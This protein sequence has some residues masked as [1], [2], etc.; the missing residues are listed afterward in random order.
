MFNL[1]TSDFKLARL[2]VIQGHLLAR[3]SEPNK[4]SCFPFTLNPAR[5]SWQTRQDKK[6]MTGSFRIV[7]N[8]PLFRAK[9]ELERRLITWWPTVPASLVGVGVDVAMMEVATTTE[10]V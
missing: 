8:M 10:I 9:G 7:S 6:T 5:T 2:H 1:S 3:W 4:V